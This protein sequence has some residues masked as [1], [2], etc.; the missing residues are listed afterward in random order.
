[1][2][3]KIDHDRPGCIGCCAC[4]AIAPDFWVME[5]DGKSSVIG[6]KHII[7][8]DDIKRE[9]KDIEE[10]DFAVNKEAAESCPV[11]VIHILKDEEKII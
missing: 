9:E 4:A 10:K 1:M 7:E 2:K 3:I 5:K 6:S 8:N 11:N